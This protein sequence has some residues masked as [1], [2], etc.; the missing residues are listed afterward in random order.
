MGLV[1]F[2]FWVWA[3][4]GLIMYWG[5][6]TWVNFSSAVILRFSASCLPCIAARPLKA[7][8][9][10]TGLSSWSDHVNRKPIV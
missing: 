8:P 6:P 2:G 5:P 7:E 9:R 1:R 4:I 3:Y 10:S